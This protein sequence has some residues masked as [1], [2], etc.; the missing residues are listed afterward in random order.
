MIPS[1]MAGAPGSVHRPSD[2]FQVDPRDEVHPSVEACADGSPPARVGCHHTYKVDREDHPSHHD[3]AAPSARSRS[4]RLKT[5]LPSELEALAGEVLKVFESLP[6][7]SLRRGQNSAIGT[8]RSYSTGAYVLGGNVGL[9]ANASSRPDVLEL[10]SKFVNL[11]VPGFQ[12][13][14]TLQ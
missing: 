6:A 8:T 12:Y 7:D 2:G 10:F 14:S 5:G 11:C 3:S 4:P 13:S 9:K 1:V